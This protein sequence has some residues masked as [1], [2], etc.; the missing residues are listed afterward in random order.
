MHAIDVLRVKWEAATG[1]TVAALVGGVDADA[2]AVVE[3]LGRV[4]QI[5]PRL[6]VDLGRVTSIDRSGL[7]LVLRLGC[8]PNVTMRS[9]SAPVTRLLDELLLAAA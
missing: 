8:I 7:D 2:A 3:G 5:A 6:V 1:S 9:P 4:A